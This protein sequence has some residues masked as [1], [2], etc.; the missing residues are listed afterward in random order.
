MSPGKVKHVSSV[1]PLPKMKEGKARRH[2]HGIKLRVASP[3][4]ASVGA[5]S[6]LRNLRS[7]K[8]NGKSRKRSESSP[9]DNRGGKRVISSPFS[10]NN[11]S[12]VTF[13]L[14]S[15]TIDLKF[16]PGSSF[17]SHSTAIPI[18][19]HGVAK[20]NDGSFI[21][22]PLDKRPIDSTQRD[23]VAKSNG[24]E[25]RFVDTSMEEGVNA[26]C[27]Q[28]GNKDSIAMA[29][30]GDGLGIADSDPGSEH[31][32]MED[33]VNT[34]VKTSSDMDGSASSK[35]GKGF[36]FGKN[37]RGKGILEKPIGP[38]FTVQF[39]KNNIQNPFVKKSMQQSGGAWNAS[40]IKGFGNPI[41]SNQYT[42]DANR[43]AEKLKQ[44]SEELALKMEYTPSAVSK[45]DNGNRRIQFSAEEVYKGGQACSLQLYGYFVGTSMDYRVV[46]S[47]LMKMWRVHGVEEIT[48]TSSGIYY[49]KFNNEEGMKTVLDCGPWMIQN[50]PLVL[51]NWE[52]GIWLDKTEPSSI[53]IWVC[54]YNIPMELCNGNGIGKIMSGVG[55]PM[56]MDRMTKER[57]LKKAGKLDYARVLVEVSASEELPS[58]LEIEYPPLGNRPAKV[59]K[60]EVKYQWKP[61]LCTHCKTFGHTTIVCKVRPRTVEEVAANNVELNVKSKIENNS[62]GVDGDGFVTVGKKNKPVGNVTKNDVSRQYRNGQNGSRHGVFQKKA[63]NKQADGKS[64]NVEHSNVSNQNKYQPKNNNYVERNLEM[65]SGPKVI[66][67][68]PLQKNS[69]HA[70]APKSLQQLSKDPSFHPKVLLRGS[71]SKTSANMVSNESI[72]VKNSYQALDNLDDVDMGQSNVVKESNAQEEF[73]NKVWP[74]LKEEVDILLE[75]GIYPSRAVRLEWSTHQLDYF[76]K[77]CH[78]FHLD[79]SYE[80]DD[81]DSDQDGI[82][83]EMKFEDDTVR[84]RIMGLNINASAQ[85]F[86]AANVWDFHVKHF[87]DVIGTIVSISNHIP[88][89][90]FGVDKLRRTVILDDAE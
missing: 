8:S 6:V 25:S 89:N 24:P 34:G 20:G 76:Y 80:D 90:N 74:A 41:L 71:G 56:V 62:K 1:V 53:P 55:K 50:V 85:V 67:V 61:P 40:G 78:K 35:A 16:V 48:K 4:S 51:N 49:F 44:G 57:C 72:P 33:V 77:N 9:I 10:D 88:F 38:F 45:Q 86:E 32:S 19:S 84:L 75:A 3:G 63:G 14:K 42:A 36:E 59:G 47:N 87:P 30:T 79:P 2:R 43:F 69:K 18:V 5:G 83:N 17:K 64:S 11:A 13:K 81:V 66:H 29:E 7:S 65:K 23:P 28:P 31:T 70:S 46:R 73:N 22:L 15:G 54:V 12:D 58:V 52:P 21:K 82:A 27:E 37:D 68:N 39:G 60:L 26:S